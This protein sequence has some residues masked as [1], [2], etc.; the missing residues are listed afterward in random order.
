VGKAQIR[1]AGHVH[2]LPNNRMPKQHLYGEL[3]HGK[4]SVDGQKKGFKNTL[5][6]SGGGTFF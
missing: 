4:R 6:A 1:W 5:K 2:Q 3:V